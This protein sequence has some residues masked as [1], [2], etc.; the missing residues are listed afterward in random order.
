M[1]I[2]FLILFINLTYLDL[3]DTSVKMSSNGWSWLLNDRQLSVWTHQGVAF[4]KVSFLTKLHLYNQF[5]FLF[6]A[7]LAKN[8]RF[9][10]LTLLLI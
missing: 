4:Y 5:F 3:D 10:F 2:N 6:R 9:P 8:Y 1:K 7:Q